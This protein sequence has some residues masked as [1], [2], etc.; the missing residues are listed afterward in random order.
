[1]K[2]A[3]AIFLLMLFLFNTVGYKLFISFKEDEADEAFTEWLDKG[4]YSNQDLV[5]VKVPINLPYQN[6][7][8]NYERIN[9]QL[10]LNGQVY[11][12]VKRKVYNDTMIYLC[13]RH[14]SKTIMEQKAN[15][16]IGKVNELPAAGNT[17]KADTLKQLFSDFNI[18]TV[19]SISELTVNPYE[20]NLYRNH[21]APDHYISKQGQ[22]P[23]RFI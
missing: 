2:K 23:R 1:M 19:L 3:A 22:P 15:D 5:A 10:K 17:K 21:F 8:S 16:Y 6:N 18:H 4:D 9:G 13:I 14:D 11:K 7:W 20:Y 12:Y